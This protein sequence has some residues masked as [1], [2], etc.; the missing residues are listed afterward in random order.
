MEKLKLI[1]GFGVAIAFIFVGSS[2]LPATLD[3]KVD[4]KTSTVKWTGYHLAKSY[5]H[6]GTILLKKGN[7]VFE[8]GN[9]TGGAFVL[10]MHSIKNSDLTKKGKNDKLVEHLK[11]EDFFYVR[12]Y[13][14]STLV[15]TEATAQDNDI[16]NITSKLYMLNLCS[17]E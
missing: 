12:K 6:F 9:L 2:F 1:L 4:P 11:S 13:P 3:Y 15:I 17:F 10:N 14:T 7:L 5:E 16:Y 8:D